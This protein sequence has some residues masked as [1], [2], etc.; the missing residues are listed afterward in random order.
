MEKLRGYSI[1]FA[2]EEDDVFKLPEAG[3]KD[4]GRGLAM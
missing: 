2:M 4:L 3:L 1:S